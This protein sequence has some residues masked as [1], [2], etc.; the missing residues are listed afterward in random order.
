MTGPNDSAV[1]P[2]V[3]VYVNERG[4]NVARGARAVD[5]VR[6]HDADD[7]ARVASGERAIVDSRGL[8]IA[9]DSPVHGGA[10]YRTITARREASAPPTDDHA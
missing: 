10:I 8:P 5:A 2:D 9:S 1:A 4:V 6:A 3:R 7:A